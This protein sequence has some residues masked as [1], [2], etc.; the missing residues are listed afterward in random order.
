MASAPVC[1]L[2]CIDKYAY[3]NTCFLYEMYISTHMYHV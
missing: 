1:V 3:I 2:V